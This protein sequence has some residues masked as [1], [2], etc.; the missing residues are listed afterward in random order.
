MRRD[1]F[2]DREG[3]MVIWGR[4]LIDR[5]HA[6]EGHY[7]MN[8]VFLAEL[9]ETFQ[10][11]E[12]SYRVANDPRTRTSVAVTAKNEARRAFERL[13]RY[14]S[15]GLQGANLPDA[16]KLSLGLNVRKPRARHVAAPAAA[17]DV[18]ARAEGSIVTVY[19][20]DAERP[21]SRARPDAATAALVF[22]HVGEQPLPPD[23]RW[24]WARTAG[25]T[26]TTVRFDPTLPP[27]TR[28][29]VIARWKNRRGE[30][31]AFS[32]PASTVL[33][34]GT[35]LLGVRP[36]TRVVGLGRLPCGTDVDVARAA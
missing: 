10:R 4:N 3:D 13:A 11:F 28:V 29:W 1:F 31:G 14:A 15:R 9:T 16:E 19:L 25:T 24:E 18:R 36:G 22:V 30:L 8:P 12:D 27:G 26:E 32:Q 35:P 2:P 5:V 34:Q 33:G 21:T 23:G 17:P 20:R 6:R 7:G